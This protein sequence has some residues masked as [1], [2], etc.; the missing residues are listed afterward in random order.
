MRC[1]V[2]NDG[3]LLEYDIRKSGISI[4]DIPRYSASMGFEGTEKELIKMLNSSKKK[5]ESF[6]KDINNAID[7]IKKN[8]KK[9]KNKNT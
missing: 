6:V 5:F 3:Y 9:T 1:V 2:F 8:D 7:F 4:S